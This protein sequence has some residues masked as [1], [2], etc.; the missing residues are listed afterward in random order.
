[1]LRFLDKHFGRIIFGTFFL[2]LYFQTEIKRCVYPFIYGQKTNAVL[3]IS[4]QDYF[5]DINHQNIP[6]KKGKYTYT[7]KPKTVYSVTGRVGIVDRYDTLFN[8]FYRGQFQGAYIALVPQ[9][10]FLVIGQM[11]DDDIFQKFV[12]EH[13]ERLGRVLCKGV[14]YK[15]SFLSSFSSLKQAQESMEKYK[16]CNHYIKE[17]EQNNYHPIPASKNINKALSMLKKGDVVYL[18]GF[19]VDVDPLGLKT[20]TRKKQH[21]QNI[22]I[23]GMQ[24]GMCFVLYTTKVILNGYQYT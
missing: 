20:G 23:N 3:Q 6:Y 16:E 22:I 17:E 2:F 13:E 11:A 24:P 15:K 18:E 10:V 14:K 12:F 5:E 21:H 8:R 7:L 4:A 19:L 1:M 9:D